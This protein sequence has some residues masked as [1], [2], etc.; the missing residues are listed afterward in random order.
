MSN[1]VI[2]TV[3]ALSLLV[4][5][6]IGVWSYRRTRTVE[7]FFIY[8]QAAGWFAIGLAFWSSQLSGW[9]LVGQPGLVYSI[10]VGWMWAWAGAILGIPIAWILLGRKLRVLSGRLK[11]LTVPDVVYHRY[12]SNLVRGLTA[13]AIIIGVLAYLGAQ[14]LA[15]GTILASVLGISLTTAVIS[16]FIVLVLYSVVG[17]QMAAIDTDVF[18]GS[19]MIVSTLVCG[20]AAI[21]F[22][23]GTGALTMA[24]GAKAGVWGSWGPLASLSFLMLFVAGN[25]GQPHLVH[26]FFMTKN[27]RVLRWGVVIATLAVLPVVLFQLTTGLYI[28]GLVDSG[29]LAA[30]ATPD[31]LVPTFLLRY[32]SPVLA[33]LIF[34]GALAASLSTADAFLNIGT[35]AFIRDLPLAFGRTIKSELSLARIVTVFLAIGATL[36]AIGAKELIGILGAIGWGFFAGALTPVIAIGM[37]WRRA[38]VPG[39]VTAIIG[40]LVVNLGLEMAK[41]MGVY[42]LPAG[43]NN[44]TVAILVSVVLF[45]VVS[46]ATS[47]PRVSEQVMDIV[48]G[49]GGSERT[50]P[51]PST[52]D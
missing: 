7:D 35:A 20:I 47:S 32:V 50:G 28:R 46:V 37:N 52:A 40:S 9:A 13:V 2:V 29:S 8:G 25:C 14:I 23:G 41:R 51:V 38:T 5:L 18:Q 3:V 27:V 31:D 30:L 10:G 45:T 12:N 48:D 4:T 15:A 19:I 21:S 39:A 11:I 42:T 16:S 34:S 24:A 49:G 26:K 33:G 17:G 1:P 43:V 22:A 44:G 6:G 36:V